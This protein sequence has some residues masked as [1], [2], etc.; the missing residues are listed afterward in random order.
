MMS[1]TDTTAQILKEQSV[2]LRKNIFFRTNTKDI[3]AKLKNRS[4]DN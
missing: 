1:T 3:V 2:L 4:Q